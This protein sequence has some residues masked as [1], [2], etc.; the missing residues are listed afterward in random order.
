VSRTSPCLSLSQPNVAASLYVSGTTLS[1]CFRYSEQH[2]TYFWTAGQRVVPSQN[3]MFVWRVKSSDA[4]TET[5]SSM[6][7]TN[8]HTGQP[9]HQHNQQSC[10]I[11]WSGLSYTWDDND[12]IARR[13][14]LSA[15][16]IYKLARLS[17][18]FIAH[19]CGKQ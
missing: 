14:V 11:I 12:C 16:S 10:V 5:L 17:R 3:S 6:A 7:Y 2:G 8:W 13:T 1:R 15:N 4:N 19:H 9:D 18:L